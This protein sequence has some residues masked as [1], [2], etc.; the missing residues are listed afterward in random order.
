[1]RP[2][3][4]RPSRAGRRLCW[5]RPS[6]IC[7]PQDGASPC[8]VTPAAGPPPQRV[9]SRGSRRVVG[10]TANAGS[11]GGPSQGHASR[12]SE[13]DAT[14]DPRSA[15]STDKSSHCRYGNFLDAGGRSPSPRCPPMFGP[16]AVTEGAPEESATAGWA[17]QSRANG[18]RRVRSAYTGWSGV[19]CS[20]GGASEDAEFVAFGV[21]HHHEAAAGFCARFQFVGGGAVVVD[22]GAQGQEPLD[23]RVARAVGLEVEMDAVLDRLGVWVLPE[24]QRHRV[25]DDG[26]GGV[27][28]EVVVGELAVEH[29]GPEGRQGVR[30]VGVE[31]DGADGGGHTADSAADRRR[32]LPDFTPWRGLASGG[33]GPGSRIPSCR[34]GTGTGTARTR[35]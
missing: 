14:P 11:G 10:S 33:P 5:M 22:G 19:G 30:V 32:P 3:G 35:P 12:L 20:F 9:R 13:R 1:M 2:P 16:P 29:L 7:S 25:G 18:K 8:R 23:L 26:G 6:I 17:E 28:R 24:E 21:V 4:R 34:R 31:G 15:V 27:A